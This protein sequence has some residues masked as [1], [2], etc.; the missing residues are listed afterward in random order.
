MLKKE[1]RTE[2]LI[3]RVSRL[4]TPQQTL[5]YYKRNE[6]LFTPL[7]PRRPSNFYTLAYQKLSLEY[8]DDEWASGRALKL[9]VFTKE[10][11]GKII[12]MVSFSSILGGSVSS[13]FL[14]YKLDQEYL[15]RGYITE[16]IAM[17]IKIIFDVYRLNRIDVAVLPRNKPSLRVMEKLGFTREGFSEKYLEINGVWEDHVRFGM[18]NV[19]DA[20][21][22]SLPAYQEKE[23]KPDS[24]KVKLMRMLGKQS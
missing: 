18:V 20:P 22:R 8:D 7:D 15:N 9:W 16:A 11:P 5:D 21:W 10:D 4:V 2:R 13:A 1:Y 23:S 17:G 6:E 12:G 19:P 3:L 14:A 24:L